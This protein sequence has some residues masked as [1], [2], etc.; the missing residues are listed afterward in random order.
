MLFLSPSVQV[1]SAENSQKRRSYGISGNPR[2]VVQFLQMC[3][4]KAGKCLCNGIF[5]TYALIPC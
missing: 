5:K 4:R 2:R 1:L 3:E